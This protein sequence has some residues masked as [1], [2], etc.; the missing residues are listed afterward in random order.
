MTEIGQTLTD[1]GPPNLA[2]LLPGTNPLWW[3][4]L[5][6]AVSDGTT[7]QTKG[8]IMKRT[9]RA[10]FA[11]L[12]AVGAIVGAGAALS[13]T[14]W[15][16]AGA[17]GDPQTS[18]Q[19]T[20]TASTTLIALQTEAARL[21]GLLNNAAASGPVPQVTSTTTS[22]PDPAPVI[23]TP[24]PQPAPQPTHASTGASGATGGAN[25]EQETESEGRDD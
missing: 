16:N 20:Q 10:T 1:S 6:A 25:S 14:A 11:A 4:T 17:Q 23:V 3:V 13:G 8:D 2:L 15:V 24:Q 18:V 9:T 7:R 5:P 22:T 12:S 21:R 19:A